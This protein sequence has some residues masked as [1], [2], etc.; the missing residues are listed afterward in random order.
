LYIQILNVIIDITLYRSII[1]C[2]DSQR[3]DI[4]KGNINDPLGL[5]VLGFHYILYLL[6]IFCL[7]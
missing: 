5:L 2:G 1:D 7:K 4:M 6:M 3:G